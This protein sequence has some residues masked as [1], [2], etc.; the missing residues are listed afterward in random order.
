MKRDKD[1]QLIL[2]QLRKIPI[3]EV[4]CEKVK[5]ATSTYYRWREDLEFAA[6]ADAAMRDGR[7][8]I[9]DL[10]EAQVVTLIKEKSWP[11]ISFWL[12]ANHPRYAHRLEL[13][14]RIEHVEKRA[15]TAE[16]KALIEKS[17]RLAMPS[18]KSTQET[19]KRPEEKSTPPDGDTTTHE[20]QQ[21]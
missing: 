8:F 14:G 4:A 9:N 20:P 3:V 13:E 5:I 2:A 6:A 12:R 18:E 21:P 7:L 1:Q 16:D 19:A 11:A 15:M 17:L 10:S